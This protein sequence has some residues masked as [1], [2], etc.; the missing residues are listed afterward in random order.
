M[1]PD[2]SDDDV[3]TFVDAAW[4]AWQAMAENAGE[5]GTRYYETVTQAI[6]EE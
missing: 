2:F 1:L 6:S 3:E 4:Q 5:D